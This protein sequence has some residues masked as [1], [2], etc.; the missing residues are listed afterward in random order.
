MVGISTVERADDHRRR[1]RNTEG[2]RVSLALFV[3]GYLRLG[4]IP[5]CCMSHNFVVTKRTGAICAFWYKHYRSRAL[6]QMS[7][8]LCARTLLVCHKPSGS[9]CLRTQPMS[10]LGGAKLRYFGAIS[11]PACNLQAALVGVVL[12]EGGRKGEGRRH[13][14]KEACIIL[15]EQ[16]VWTELSKCICL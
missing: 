8:S 1:R 6:P 3:A 9:I 10:S 15:L 11:M 7:P 13:N 12:E 16:R 2:T 5:V 4:L 14:I